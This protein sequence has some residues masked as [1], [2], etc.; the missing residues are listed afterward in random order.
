[1]SLETLRWPRARYYIQTSRSRICVSGSLR[2]PRF[3]E[4]GERKENGV[5]ADRAVGLRYPARSVF[6]IALSVLQRLIAVPYGENKCTE[7][8][9]EGRGGR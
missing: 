3:E 6:I 7:Q 9:N 2:V 4:R 1:M 5:Y 8:G